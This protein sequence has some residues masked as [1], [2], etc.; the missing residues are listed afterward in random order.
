M[1]YCFDSILV[2]NRKAYISGWATG[3]EKDH[4]VEAS[5]T[6]IHGRTAPA[7]ITWASRPDVG[8]AKFSD[9]KA[10]NVGLFLE[11]PL[12]G[13]PIVFVCLTEYDPEHKIILSSE[14]IP[15]NAAIIAARL[16]AKR[17]KREYVTGKKKLIFLK[18]KLTGKE[19]AD[20]DTW[21]RIM[22]V[23]WKELAEQRSTVLPS[24]PL[25]SIIVPLYHTKEHFLRDLLDSVVGQSYGC[26]E[27]I[28]VNASPEDE[29]ISKVLR[30]WMAKD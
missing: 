8:L 17:A 25:F 6:D 11:I 27:L 23:N 18:Q 1:E 3:S 2:K 28:L 9:T 5:V 30:K 16:G 22:R 15:L 26:W 24:T 19:Y 4:I 7:T 21:F 10:E 29:R 13:K 20:Y 12:A 14:K